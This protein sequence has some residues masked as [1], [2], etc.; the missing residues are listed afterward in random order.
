M[1]EHTIHNKLLKMFLTA[2]DEG[3]IHLVRLELQTRYPI[4]H[5]IPI[6]EVYEHWEN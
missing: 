5:C 2:T 1:N 6:R 3:I 4:Y